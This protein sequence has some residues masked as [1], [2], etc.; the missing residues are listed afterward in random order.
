MS[1]VTRDRT[2]ILAGIAAEVG[3]LRKS[4]PPLIEP[5]DTFMGDLGLSSLDVLK[6]ALALENRFQI[7]IEQDAEFQIKNAGEL[8][9]YIEARLDAAGAPAQPHTHA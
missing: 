7:T 6:L 4:E 9:G 8:A 3:V 1:A 5:K 2:A